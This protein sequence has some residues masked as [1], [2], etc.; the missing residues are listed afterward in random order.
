MLK[1]VKKQG[2]KEQ[3]QHTQGEGGDWQEKKGCDFK[4][5]N[6]YR[7]HQESNI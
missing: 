5:D 4:K 7:P 1:A 3:G 6:Q 2:G